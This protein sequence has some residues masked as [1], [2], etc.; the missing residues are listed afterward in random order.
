MGKIKDLEGMK[1]GRL[2]ITTFSQVRNHEAWW[3]C[4]CDCGKSVTKS[5]HDLR[6]GRVKSCGCLQPEVVSNTSR[7][8]GMNETKEYRAWISMKARCYNTKGRLYKHWGGRGISVCPQWKEDFEQFHKDMGPKPTPK[9]SLDRIDVNGNY[10]PGN[11]RWATRE[12]Q[13]NNTTRSNKL[14]YNGETKTITEWAKAAGMSNMGLYNRIQSGWSIERA[15]T[16]PS[17]KKRVTK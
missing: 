3:N 2:S 9:H 15:L 14:I 7:I 4:I 11:C 16:K 17:Q 12:E 5:G 1:F 10:E 8:H 13:D 6:L